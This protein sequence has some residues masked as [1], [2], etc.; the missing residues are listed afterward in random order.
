MSNPGR[1]TGRKRSGTDRDSPPAAEPAPR[2]DLLALGKVVKHW[3][4]RGGVKVFSYAE[5]PDSFRR[6]GHLCVQGPEGLIDLE[7]KRVREHKGRV[8]LEFKGRERIED[9]EE[10]IGC[11]LYMYK[12]DLEPLEEGEYYWHQLIGMG[13]WTE[14]GEHLGTLAEIMPTGGHDVYVVK[15]DNREWLIPATEDV[16]REVDP[17]GGK[18]VIRP[19][20]GMLEENDL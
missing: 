6:I 15:R 3:G 12:K 14:A 7:I 9:V 10:L 17:D 20:E 16:I 13:V 11:L 19:L 2:E 18:M 1:R 4:L 8:H 5:S